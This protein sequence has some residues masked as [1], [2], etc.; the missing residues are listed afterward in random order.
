[1]GSGAFL[2]A[3]CRY[4]ASAAED[5]L[6]QEGRWHAHDVTP[7]DRVALRREIASRCL[8]GV[9]LNPMAVQLARLSLWLA[10]LAADKPLSFL[11][12]H[13]VAG[14]QPRRRHPRGHE[15]PARRRHG[16][17]R[18]ERLSLFDETELPSALAH[19]A[20]VMSKV[21]TEP[22]DSADVVRAKER[23]LQAL[24]SGDSSLAKWK[25]ALD[26]WCA[27]WFWSEG[28]PPDRAVFL[29]LVGRL[30]ESPVDAAH[31][32]RRRV[33]SNTP[34]TVADTAS[35][36]ALAADIPDVFSNGTAQRPSR[37]RRRCR[38]PAVGHGPRRQRRRGDQGRQAC[39]RRDR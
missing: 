26:L 5:A 13:L 19:A 24:Q 2:V 12:H 22:D 33:C 31:R 17:K 20:R 32:M 8:F 21:S 25:A 34:R 4:L 3:A 18:Q 14:P 30:L 38:Q 23:T 11:D 29:D 37:L 6:V 9:D 35:L 15:P 36:S 16:R 10:T 28:T 1:M 39:S 7:A 27:A